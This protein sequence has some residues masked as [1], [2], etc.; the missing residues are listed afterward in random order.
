MIYLDSSVA[1]AHILN[2]ARRPSRAF[3]EPNVTSSRLL[4]YEVINRLNAHD[5]SAERHAIAHELLGS[6][7]YAEMTEQA[8]V[9]ALRPLPVPVRTL[10][11]LH[12]ATMHY[13]RE[14]GLPLSLASYDARLLAAADAMGFETVEP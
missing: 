7:Q 10:D 3:W 9:R 14:T 2:E 8:L 6:V 13:L 12:L 5:V 1:L 11:G 4:E